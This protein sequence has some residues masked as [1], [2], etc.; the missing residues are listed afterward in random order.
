MSMSVEDVTLFNRAGTEKIS[1]EHGSVAGINRAQFPYDQGLALERLHLLLIDD[2][3][4][5]M[6]DINAGRTCDADTAI[7][8]IQQH[9]TGQR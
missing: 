9:R 4:R 3:K 1:A 5:G 8:Q 6:A 2:A 7:A